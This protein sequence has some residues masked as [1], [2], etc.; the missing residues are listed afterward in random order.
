MFL[1]VIVIVIITLNFTLIFYSG[2]S[3]KLL[4]PLAFSHQSVK[5][6]EMSSERSSAGDCSMYANVDCSAVRCE[7]QTVLTNRNT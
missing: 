6:P 1:L 3:K 2:P 4:G 7:D 5:R